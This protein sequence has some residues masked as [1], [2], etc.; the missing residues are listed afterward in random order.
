MR[1]PVFCLSLLLM[2]ARSPADADDWSGAYAGVHF[3][4]GEGNQQI[5]N[6]FKTGFQ[7]GNRTNEKGALA[8]LQGGYNWQ[9]DKFVLGAEVD[10]SLADITGTASC[11]GQ[12]QRAECKPYVN[13]LGTLAAKFGYSFGDTLLYGK[14]GAAWINDVDRFLVYNA[15]ASYPHGS[16]SRIGFTFGAGMEHWLSDRWS[17]SFEYRYAQFG[18]DSV[19][20]GAGDL[21]I[22]HRLSTAMVGVNYWFDRHERT[23][24][25]TVATLFDDDDAPSDWSLLLTARYFNGQGTLKRDIDSQDGTN[26]NSRLIY[27]GLNPRQFEGSARFELS[28]GWFARLTYGHGDMDGRA[29][30]DEDTPY[31][32]YDGG[33]YSNSI[34][35]TRNGSTDFINGDIGHEIVSRDD[36]RLG[37]YLGYQHFREQTNAY[38]CTQIAHNRDNCGPPFPDNFKSLIET[39]NWDSVRVGI[40]GTFA[41][42]DRLIFTGDFAYLPYSAFHGTD[43][44]QFRQIVFHQPGHGNGLQLEGSFDFAVTDALSLG[45]GARYW[46]WRTTSGV[47]VCEGPCDSAVIKNFEAPNGARSDTHFFGE[48]V[49]L[50]YL[51]GDTRGNPQMQASMP[52]DAGAWAVSYI[53]VALGARF[54]QSDWKTPCTGVNCGAGFLNGNA[55]PFTSTKPYLGAYGGK[56]WQV[57][58]T[59][60]LGAELDGG[61]ANNREKHYDV[62][63]A[64][65][66]SPTRAIPNDPASLKESWDGS[67]RARGGFLLSQDTLAYAVGGVAMQQAHAAITCFVRP[68]QWCSGPA[69]ISESASKTAWGWIA[70]FG[71]E[72]KLNDALSARLEYTYSDEGDFRHDFIS[73]RPADAFTMSARL[74]ES[75]LVAGLS[76]QLP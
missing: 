53:G 34:S 13:A 27:G 41:I 66:G 36:A 74:R 6:P 40:N 18:S 63:A 8:G 28:E 75:R 26:E 47:S 45:V 30:F 73:A 4:G 39:D 44:H 25:D 60:L 9:F 76:Y 58:D 24:E 2:V 67:L 62:W 22:S 19:N 72:T 64:N 21:G 33:R 37:V 57:S 20:V 3:G 50:S 55:V 42:T 10:F 71:L 1:L 15:V 29:M 68:G 52:P 12:P 56:L 23:D 31:A 48:F 59:W 5:D 16:D 69:T 38:G 14:A 46:Q 61:R 49:Q 65:I 7:F 32:G 54:G 17:L 43:D 11:L 70:G 35:D 51:F